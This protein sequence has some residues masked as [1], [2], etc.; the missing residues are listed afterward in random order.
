MYSLLF[1]LLPA[2]LLPSLTIAHPPHPE[3]PPCLT[4]SEANYLATA[5]LHIWDTNA[6]S[7]LADL[8]PILSSDIASYD[9]SYGGPTLGI[10]A[11]LAE[12]TA[13]GN[14]TTTDISQFPLFVIHSCDQVV[15]RWGYTALTTG[16]ES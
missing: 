1:T 6:V 7:S 5:W 11:L 13:P 12:L 14:Y 16:Y 15:T 8:T 9:E 10:D 2:F 3:G 4:T